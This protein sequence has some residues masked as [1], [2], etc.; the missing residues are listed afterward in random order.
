MK[1]TLDVEEGYERQAHH[2][3]SMDTESSLSKADGCGFRSGRAI[4]ES[5][6]LG[7]QRRRP[8][9]I[10]GHLRGRTHG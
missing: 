9:G 5:R 4:G 1:Q 10:W 2:G 8:A 7:G 6:G 3:R